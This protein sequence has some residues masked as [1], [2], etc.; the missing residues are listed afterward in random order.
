MNLSSWG[1][2]RRSK[3]VKGEEGGSVRV[4]KEEGWR[5]EDTIRGTATRLWERRNRDE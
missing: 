4:N 3:T 2:T 5:T 1:N